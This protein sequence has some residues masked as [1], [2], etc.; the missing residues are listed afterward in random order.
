MLRYTVLRVLVFFAALALL[1]L[2]GLR[3]DENLLLLVVGAA[4]LSAVVS[5][6]ALRRFREDTSAQIAERLE[7][8]AGSRR[9]PDPGARADEEVEDAEVEQRRSPAPPADDDGGDDFR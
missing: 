1:W 8:R 6:F 4:L 7:H 5:F 3:G 2:V 9:S